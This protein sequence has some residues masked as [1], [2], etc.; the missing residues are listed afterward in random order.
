VQRADGGRGA[1]VVIPHFFRNW[2]LEDARRL[3]LN[4]ICWTAKLDIP[5]EGVQTMLPNLAEFA[6]DSVDPQPRPKPQ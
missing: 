6:P 2:G 4:S 3:V 5:A 1:G